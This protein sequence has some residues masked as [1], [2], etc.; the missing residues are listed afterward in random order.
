MT[1]DGA[2]ESVP[3]DDVFKQQAERVRLASAARR[4]A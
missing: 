2:V 3:K 4:P 1:D